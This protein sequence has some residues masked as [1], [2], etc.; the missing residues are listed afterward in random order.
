MGLSISQ[1]DL[2]ITRQGLLQPHTKV[3][4]RST[5]C[6]DEAQLC[7]IAE[8]VH[9]CEDASVLHPLLL[10]AAQTSVP[11]SALEIC[12]ALFPNSSRGACI[13]VVSR[14]RSDTPQAHCGHRALVADWPWPCRDLG[15][16]GLPELSPL[17]CLTVLPVALPR[18][19]SEQENKS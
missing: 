2:V 1:R 19:S 6:Q 5:V 15:T 4:M 7:R 9:G 8:S 3:S 18:Q 11:K 14:R 17:P 12:G 16:R 13:L 10:K